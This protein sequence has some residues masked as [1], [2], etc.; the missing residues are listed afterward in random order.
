MKVNQITFNGEVQTPVGSNGSAN[1]SVSSK[2]KLSIIELPNI[3]DPDTIQ[4]RGKPIKEKKVK[5]TE[6]KHGKAA[7]ERDGIKKGIRN[8]IIYYPEAD[9]ADIRASAKELVEW[10]VS[11][12]S[13]LLRNNIEN[14]HFM[15]EL[16]SSIAELPDTTDSRWVV[17]NFH[18]LT[19]K[20]SVNLDLCRNDSMFSI[21]LLTALK[22]RK[23]FESELVSVVKSLDAYLLQV[24]KDFKVRGETAKLK[25]DRKIYPV[26]QN[27][28]I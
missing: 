5:L 19:N 21:Q 3:L 15:A 2:G 10:Y 6:R 24:K 1:G 28:R 16:H 14:V 8:G 13:N 12:G 22:K 25:S 4:G 20:I 26:H 27:F 11:P 7:R 23:S 17:Y 18:V 9:I